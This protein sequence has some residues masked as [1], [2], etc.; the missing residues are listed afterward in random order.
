VP[1][2]LASGVKDQ[3]TEHQHALLHSHLL[4]QRALT[5]ALVKEVVCQISPVAQLHHGA[6]DEVAI[7]RVQEHVHVQHYARVPQ[8]LRR[9]GGHPQSRSF[10]K[11]PR[12]CDCGQGGLAARRTARGDLP[13][14][15]RAHRGFGQPHLKNFCFS[16]RVIS[17]PDIL[18]LRLFQDELAT[19]CLS[20]YAA[21]HTLPTLLLA[22]IAWSLRQEK[23]GLGCVSQ[24]HWDTFTVA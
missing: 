8:P 22:T 12:K 17:S 16:Q 11:L 3:S 2:L 5:F 15:D 7:C 10:H 20:L 14:A 1:A 4:G 13:P 21:R 9:P 24:G 19:V 6:H 18:A 23:E